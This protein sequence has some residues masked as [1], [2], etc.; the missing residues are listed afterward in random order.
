VAAGDV[1]LIREIYDRWLRGDSVR[2]LVAE[3][4][5]YVNPPEAVEG[6]T[7]RGRHVLGRLSETYADVKI[8]PAQIV[9]AGDG[10][11]AVVANLEGVARASGVFIEWQLGFVWTVRDGQAVRFEWFRDPAEALRAAG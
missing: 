10:R 6:G 7:K 4:L 11:V 5:E 9:D 8:T 2:G 3:D 1:E